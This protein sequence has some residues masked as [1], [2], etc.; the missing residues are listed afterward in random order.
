MST[1]AL[2]E[3]ELPI[4]VKALTDE[5]L[6]RVRKSSTVRVDP[7]LT[8]LQADTALPILKVF[9]SEMHDESTIESPTLSLRLKEP[10]PST[11]TLPPILEE[12][13]KSSQ[14][15]ACKNRGEKLEHS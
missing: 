1:S 7:S 9:L 12:Q 2:T 4:L 6:D 15:D 5:E 8:L 11:L 14:Y 13:R 3:R 10:A